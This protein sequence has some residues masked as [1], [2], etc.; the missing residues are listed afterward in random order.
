MGGAAIAAGTA[1][2]VVYMP[3][4]EEIIKHRD[5]ILD[6]ARRVRHFDEVNDLLNKLMSKT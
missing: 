3:V 4:N 5:E 2:K 6:W 1:R